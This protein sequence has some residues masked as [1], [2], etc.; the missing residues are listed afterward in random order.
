MVAAFFIGEYIMSW[1]DSVTDSISSVYDTVVD[2][3]TDYL[4]T[5]IDGFTSDPVTT[6]TTGSAGIG[7]NSQTLGITK[8]AENSGMFGYSWQ[9][10]ASIASVVG[11]VVFLMRA[12]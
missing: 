2:T 6:K 11:V 1:F 10:I 8:T 12:K 5:K 3:S 7:S 9:V 4:N